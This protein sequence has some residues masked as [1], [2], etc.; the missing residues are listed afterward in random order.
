MG[1][2]R[3]GVGGHICSGVYYSYLKYSSLGEGWEHLTGD[4]VK[5]NPNEIKYFFPIL[6]IRKGFVTHLLNDTIIK[7][8]IKNI[9]SSVYSKTTV[10]LFIYNFNFM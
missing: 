10:H 9:K 2:V 3:S 4:I 5:S 8:K 1:P 7:F 6:R